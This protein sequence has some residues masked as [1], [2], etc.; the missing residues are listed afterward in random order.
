MKEE[1]KDSQEIQDTQ[2]VDSI[3][4]NEKTQTDGDQDK[5]TRI[6]V[7]LFSLGFFGGLFST[8]LAYIAHF[9]KFIPFGPGILLQALPGYS[10]TGWMRGPI[11]HLIGIILIS[12]LAVLG[13][14][15][16]YKLM[17]RMNTIWAGLWYGFALWV[18]IFMGLN[19]I[20][21]GV[22][23][24]GELGWNANI[25]L[26]CIFLFYGI[27]VGYSISYEYQQGTFEQKREE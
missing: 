10:T 14:Y 18:V 25:T 9:F 12:L 27:F 3:E 20:I 16:Y 8:V 6:G 7:Y 19:Q 2:P 15:L 21:P 5:P 22:K 13:A 23:K 26:V 24:V 4:S 17:K 11:G 1:I